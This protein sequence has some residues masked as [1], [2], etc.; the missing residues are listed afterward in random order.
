MGE[1]TQSNTRPAE[2]VLAQ[3]DADGVLFPDAQNALRQRITSVE[4]LFETDPVLEEHLTRFIGLSGVGSGTHLCESLIEHREFFASLEHALVEMLPKGG[5]TTHP[6][7]VSPRSRLWSTS[8]TGSSGP[9]RSHEQGI[10]TSMLLLSYFRSYT[11]FWDADTREAGQKV[12]PHQCSN[13]GIYRH[14][15]CYFS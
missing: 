7:N 13:W 2:D 10:S 14:L 5:K 12:A 9:M 8:S 11:P 4:P 3:M 6:R 15:S 1:I